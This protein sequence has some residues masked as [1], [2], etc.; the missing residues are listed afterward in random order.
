MAYL[1]LYFEIFLSFMQVPTLLLLG[2][3]VFLVYFSIIYNLYGVIDNKYIA[4]YRASVDC[5]GMEETCYSRYLDR[6]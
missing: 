4:K 1:A 5:N 6:G 3:L 2:C